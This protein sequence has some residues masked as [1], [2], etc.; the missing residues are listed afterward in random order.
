ML[1][2]LIADGN[3][4]AARDRHVGATGETS[5]EAYARVV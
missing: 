4:R 3:D 5:A 1:R 2:L